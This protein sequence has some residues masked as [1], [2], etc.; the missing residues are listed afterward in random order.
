MPPVMSIPLA[1]V[2]FGLYHL[3][4]DIVLGRPA[5][6]SPVFA[7]FVGGYVV[8]DMVHYTLHH[9][10]SKNPYLLMCRF[11]HMQHHGACPAMRFGVSSPLW[12]YVFG[13]MPAARQKRP[14]TAADTITRRLPPPPE[15]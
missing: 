6:F 13:T 10:R 9:G 12:D 7:G 14:D 11:Q 8:Y 3:L 15:G 4:F 1:I 2:F 5:W